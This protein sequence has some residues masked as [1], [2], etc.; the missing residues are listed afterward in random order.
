[1]TKLRKFKKNCSKNANVL[2]SYAY[3]F[4]NFWI[5]GR[6]NYFMSKGILTRLRRSGS[7]WNYYKRT[8]FDSFP[9]N[10][11]TFTIN[12][13]T[14]ERSGSCVVNLCLLERRLFVWQIIYLKLKLT[15]QVHDTT[16]RVRQ[17]RLCNAKLMHI[18]WCHSKCVFIIL[19][20]FAF[21]PNYYF[22]NTVN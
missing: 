17:P 19:F 9:R 21:A 16:L 5:Q 13:S 15:V 22:P 1:M 20:C 14:W 8:A 7:L 12:C 18:R 2:I 3:P 4:I 6:R 11:W 10:E